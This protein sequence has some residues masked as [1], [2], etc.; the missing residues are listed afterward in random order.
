ML[1]LTPMPESDRSKAPTRAEKL[2][3]ELNSTRKACLERL[4]DKTRPDAEHDAD[5]EM[6]DII[7]SFLDV[8]KGPAAQA[9]LNEWKFLV[10]MDAWVERFGEEIDALVESRREKMQRWRDA[11][12][13]SGQDGYTV[14]RLEMRTKDEIWDEYYR[15]EEDTVKKWE[16]KK[17]EISECLGTSLGQDLD[18][19]RGDGDTVS[20]HMWPPHMPVKGT[21]ANIHGRRR[22]W[23][24][25][26]GWLT[27]RTRRPKSL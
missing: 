21:L 4:Q 22:I 19:A 7:T 6:Y 14:G 17:A 16:M 23:K 13:D 5:R 26:P 25:C 12:D 1:D 15:N 2:I 18:L 24:S 10:V 8:A 27:K 3:Q 20:L 9:K 11:V